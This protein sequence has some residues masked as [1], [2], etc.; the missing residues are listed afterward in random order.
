[1]CWPTASRLFLAKP[2]SIRGETIHHFFNIRVQSNATLTKHM[3]GE[4]NIRALHEKLLPVRVII[5]DEIGV[6]SVDLLGL[7]IELH[8]QA[9]RHPAES[10]AF[11]G[12]HMLLCGDFFQLPPVAKP[13]FPLYADV[14]E[15][16]APP[17]AIAGRSFF[18]SLPKFVE[19]TENW[20][21]KNDERYGNLCRCA[22]L[23]V[24]PPQSEAVISRRNAHGQ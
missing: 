1:V 2:Y 21:Q 22:R 15:R 6:V 14:D 3:K 9:M 11:H 10:P 18:R 17:F 23:G 8:R 5:I 13:P 20:R 7:V 16:V 19:L 24:E 4:K 12:M